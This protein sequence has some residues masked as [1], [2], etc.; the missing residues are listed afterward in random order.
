V[1]S[2]VTSDF[3]RDG[4]KHLAAIGL[5]SH[6]PATDF[7]GAAHNLIP[8]RFVFRQRDET[9][10]RNSLEWLGVDLE[11]APFLLQALREETSPP[12]GAG[13]QVPEERRGEM[14]MRD[15]L[16]RIGRGKVLGPARADRA[17]AIT[18]TP[19]V[20]AKTERREPEAV[21]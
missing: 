18:S 14:F 6:D 2:A 15:A 11:E 12:V 3:S 16:S 20:V 17:E 9:L 5:A 4:R 7:Q 19:T 1:G 8:N 21:R 10:A 13:R